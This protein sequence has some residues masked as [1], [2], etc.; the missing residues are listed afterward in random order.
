M[1]ILSSKQQREQKW[2]K[3]TEDKLVRLQNKIGIHLLNK[4]YYHDYL[5]PMITNTTEKYNLI[6][7]QKV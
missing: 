5:H 1:E 4:I 6:A 2:R 3:K 7:K